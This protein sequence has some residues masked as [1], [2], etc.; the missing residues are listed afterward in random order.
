MTAS[1]LYSLFFGFGAFALVALLMRPAMRLAVRAGFVD[2]PDERKAHG[3]NIPPVGGLL[4][5]PVFMLAALLSGADMAYF[6]PLMLALAVI[7]F[8]GA[9]DDRYNI[10]P[11][12][13]F[14]AQFV[15]AFILVI[16]GQAQIRLLGDLFGF[17]L[18]GLDLMTIPFSVIA[19]VLLINAI[20]LL[21]GLDGLSGGKGFVIFFWL[22]IAALLSGNIYFL[23]ELFILLGALG[24]FLLYNMRTP[25]RRRAT[26]FIGDSGSMALGAVLAWYCIWMARAESAAIHPIAVA[27]LLALPIYD[28]CGQFARRIREGRHPFDADTD[29]FHH[30]FIYSG[31]PAGRATALILTLSFIT[32]L[33]GVGGIAIGLPPFVLTYIWIA[34]LFIHIYLSMHP[35]KFRK[36]VKR[37]FGAFAGDA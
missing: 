37:L 9:L 17:G 33:L 7:L 14:A 25:L 19:A 30:H 24:G 6:W 28:T 34:L 23:P 21:D 15:A 1:L 32:G 3:A 35:E 18:V 4:I 20:N 10:R 13:K 12:V 31:I 8:T 29:H 36:I 5:F 26:V 11:W 22:I 2:K 27:W 16:P